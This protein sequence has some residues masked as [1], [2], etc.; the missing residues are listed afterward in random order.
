[1]LAERAEAIVVE[2]A[3]GAVGALDRLREVGAGRGVFIVEPRSAMPS[4]GIVPLGEQLLKYVRPREN[5]EAIARN[6]LGDVYLV[7]NL[8]DRATRTVKRWHCA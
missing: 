6:L 1:M 7:S 4:R 8:A 2:N 5:Y 3:G